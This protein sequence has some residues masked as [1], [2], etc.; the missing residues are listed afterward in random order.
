MSIGILA[1]L[2]QMASA[3]LCPNV[4]VATGTGDSIS[5]CGRVGRT[6][7]RTS[8][9]SSIGGGRNCGR[10]GSPPKAAA[11]VLVI[12]GGGLRTA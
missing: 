6:G 9:S 8:A 3:G 12:C 4:T 7:P 1:N 2:V 11:A 5:V 10:C